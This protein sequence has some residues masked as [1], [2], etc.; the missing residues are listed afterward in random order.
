VFYL[1]V[2]GYLEVLLSIKIFMRLLVNKLRKISTS[3]N[4]RFVIYLVFFFFNI[5]VR[6]RGSRR[7]F[8]FLIVLIFTFYLFFSFS[9]SIQCCYSDR[10][11]ESSW[12]R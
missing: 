9:A 10:S 6:R 1:F 3:R 4:G 5:N 12:S 2:T 8:F 11:N 7:S